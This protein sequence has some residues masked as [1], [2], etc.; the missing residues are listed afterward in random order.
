MYSRNYSNIDQL[1]YTLLYFILLSILFHQFIYT[2]LPI[3]QV[4]GPPIAGFIADKLGKYKPVLVLSLVL[5]IVTATSILFVPSSS[6]Q[7]QNDEGQNL[8]KSRGNHQLTF[9]LYFILRVL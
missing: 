7:T 1:L 2:L 4:L 8:T 3:T 6:P 9:W 5:C